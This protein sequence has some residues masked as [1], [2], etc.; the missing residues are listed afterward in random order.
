MRGICRS[1]GLALV[2][3]LGAATPAAAQPTVPCDYARADYGLRKLPFDERSLAESWS[4]DGS[5]IVYAQDGRIKVFDVDRFRTTAVLTPGEDASAPTWTS[6]GRVFFEHKRNLSPEP[7]EIFVMDANGRNRREVELTA[8]FPRGNGRDFYYGSN[9]NHAKISPDGRTAAFTMIRSGRWTIVK[10]AVVDGPNGT[11]IENPVDLNTDPYWNE[12]KGWTDDGRLLLS[13]SRGEGTDNQ[14]LNADVFTLDLASGAI[15]RWTSDPAWEE[16]A[17]VGPGNVIVFN[18]DRATPSPTAPHFVPLPNDAD[19][20]LVATAAVAIA[21]DTTTHDLFIAGPEGDR[22]WLRR[23]TFDRAGAQPKWSPDG[24]RV[25]FQQRG[26]SMLLTFN[27]PAPP[28]CLNPAVGVLGRTLGAARLGRTRR[29]QRRVLKGKLLSRRGGIDRYCVAGGGRMRIGYPTARLR[30]SHPRPD[31]VRRRRGRALIVLTSS[32]RFAIRGVRRG[33]S[34]R[35]LRGLRRFRI[36]RNLW[37]VARGKRS[38]LVFKTRRGRV[39]EVGIA[40]RRLG[41]TGAAVRRLLHAWHL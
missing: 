13:S 20:A 21:S 16:T 36:G 1:V 17:D 37:Y 34:T 22:G 14:A 31:L 6:N 24:R 27:C 2:L 10:A 40:D 26:R 32:R 15:K 23:L 18:S 12:A 28:R 9:A 30:R 8:E 39:L 38:L 41:A 5:R 25:R 11:R 33:S 29:A 19:F 3:L 35:P 4:P 7:P